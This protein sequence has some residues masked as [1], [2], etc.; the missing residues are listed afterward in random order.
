M[1]YIESSKELKKDSAKHKEQKA[2]KELCKKAGARAVSFINSLSHTSDY[3]GQPFD[4]RPWQEK[5]VRNLFGRLDLDGKRIINEAFIML[6]KKQGKSELVAAISLY[7]LIGLGKSGQSI[8]M[9]ASSREQ[10]SILYDIAAEM[11]RQNAELSE[12]IEII[13]SKKRLFYAAKNNYIAAVAADAKTAHGLN[14]SVVCFEEAHAQT[15]RKL[16]NTL[17]TS[18]GTRKEPLWITLTH[19][20]FDRQSLAFEE[21]EYACKVENKIIDN[22]HYYPVL[23][24]ATPEDD[25]TDPKVWHKCNPALGDFYSL[26]SLQQEFQ[27]AKDVPS[28]ENG[29]RTFHLNQWVGQSTRWLPMDHYNKCPQII[30]LDA[31]KGKTCYGGLDL[32][33]SDDFSALVLGF[34]E[35][36]GV[37]LL[38]SFWLPEET[39]NKNDDYRRWADQGFIKVTPGNIIDYEVIRKD[40]NDLYKQYHIEKIA[41]DRWESV[42]LST[43]LEDDGLEI[44]RFGQGFKSMSGPSKELERLILSHK[45]NH[46][47]N[48]VLKWMASNVSAELDAA[49]NIKPT[50]ESRKIKIDGVI[51]TIMALGISLEPD[52]ATPSITCF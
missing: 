31:L 15:N 21:F 16:W 35:K 17:K 8:I 28:E 19:A 38:P 3:R 34:R 18:M 44:E 40:I 37:T 7:C 13:P 29:F 42:Q 11:V 33:A 9:A 12:L 43:Q 10:A 45:L 49:G 4:L 36:D 24:Y 5:I 39:V 25:W 50:K 14:P 46:G 51:A 41:I 20:G 27:K 32:S 23:Y 26:D 52:S 48:A 22:P 1:S 2:H 47:G 6:A 30:D